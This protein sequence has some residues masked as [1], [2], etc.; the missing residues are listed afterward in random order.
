MF[1]ISSI[2]SLGTQ[3]WVIFSILDEILGQL[4]KELGE[5]EGENVAIE[6]EIEEVQRRCMEGR[7]F[8]SHF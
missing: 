6:H 5:V 7:R 4:K 3:N 8:I 1:L 2:F